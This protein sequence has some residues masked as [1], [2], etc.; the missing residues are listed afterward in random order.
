M[1][2]RCLPLLQATTR[3]LQRFVVIDELQG[4]RWKYSRLDR[5]DLIGRRVEQSLQAAT[6][7]H[8]RWQRYGACCAAVIPRL[9]RPFRGHCAVCRMSLLAPKRTST[10]PARLEKYPGLDSQ[11]TGNLLDVV[12]RHIPRV[13]LDVA[14][15]GSVKVALMG[16]RL[17]S[18]ALLFSQ[19]DQIQRQCLARGSGR[20]GHTA[21][22]LRM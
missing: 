14:N 16:Q 6:L 11:S 9:G 15:I 21:R 19:A 13:A 18:P 5:F 17:L 4:V 22:V 7:S 2:R 20:S 3:E 10:L 8:R 12:E 1:R